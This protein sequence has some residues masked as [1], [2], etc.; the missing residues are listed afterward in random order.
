M[1]SGIDDEPA[2]PVSPMHYNGGLASGDPVPVTP[3][4]D[5]GAGYPPGGAGRSYPGG[6]PPIDCPYPRIASTV[7]GFYRCPC[8]AARVRHISRVLADQAATERTERFLQAVFSGIGA[9]WYITWSSSVTIARLAARAAAWAWNRA[10]TR[11]GQEQNHHAAMDDDTEQAR[12]GPG[13]PAPPAAESSPETPL[14]PPPPKEDHRFLTCPG[15]SDGQHAPTRKEDK[16]ICLAC[17]MTIT[18]PAPTGSA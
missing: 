10:I 3:V 8:C 5:G 1:T 2:G 14:D 17:T 13:I 4:Y 12:P 9:A 18:V 15:T 11:T 6:H 7:R 16:Y